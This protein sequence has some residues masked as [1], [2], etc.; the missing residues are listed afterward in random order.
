VRG[1]ID[2]S[3]ETTAPRAE[4]GSA[5]DGVPAIRFEGVTKR[6]GETEAVKDMGIEVRRGE[7]FSLLGP[8]A[9][10]RRPP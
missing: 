7:F 8:P 9:A 5:T 4:A 1:L 2:A 3:T 10:A 6:F